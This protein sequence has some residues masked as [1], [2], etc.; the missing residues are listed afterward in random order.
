MESVLTAPAYEEPAIGRRGPWR[1]AAVRFRKQRLALAA[2]AIL[3][4]IFL[5]GAL[6]SLIAPYG[7]DHVDLKLI[8][9]PPAAPTWSHLFGTDDLGHDM[10]SQTL[11]GIRTSVEVA[12][13]VGGVAAL[14][15]IVVGVLSGYYR[16]WTD[17]VISAVVDGF[18]AIPALLAALISISAFKNVVSPWRVG[19]TLAVVLWP[20]IARVVRAS[21]VTLRERE[22]IEA[23]RASGASDARVIFRHLLPNSAGPIV[24]S[25][26]SVIGLAI[27]LEATVD[28]FNYGL[29]GALTPTLGSLLADAAK[30]GIGQ[31]WWWLYVIPALVIGLM[32][33]CVNFVGDSLDDALNPTRRLR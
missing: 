14:I 12:L 33:V 6:A 7:Y 17:R 28:F 13:M 21:F 18:V 23:A 26:T 1:Q 24:V 4:G 8:G 25:V 11:Y 10:F 16:G 9:K 22:Y 3:L 31:P 20:P 19:L 29:I 15:G 27:I 2:L 30:N 32:L 5:V